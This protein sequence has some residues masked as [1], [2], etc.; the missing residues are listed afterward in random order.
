MKTKHL[1]RL[2]TIL[3]AGLFAMPTNAQTAL[4]PGGNA[5]TLFN[6]SS[7]TFAGDDGT[8]YVNPSFFTK[9]SDGSYKFNAITGSYLLQANSTLKYLQVRACDN[10]GTLSTL[11]A[12]GT[13]AVYII[14]EGIGFPTVT[15]NQVGWNTDKAISMAQTSAKKY[16]VTGVVGQEIGTAINFKFY[17]QAGWGTEFHGS[18]G[19]DYVATS[20]SN[21]LDVGQGKDVN[22]HDDGNLFLKSGAE[23]AMGDT[24]VLTLDLTEGVKSGVLSTTLKK[25]AA[26][27][28]PTFNGNAFTNT[29]DGYIY[30][31]VITQGGT[32]TFAGASQFGDAD[33]HMDADFFQSKGDGTFTFIP[34]T[35]RYEIMAD[36]TLKY[37][38]VF[39]INDDNSVATYNKTTGL[40]GV[41]AIGDTGFGKPSFSKN[42]HNWYT[43]I[44]NDV[45]LA[46]ISNAKYQLTLNSG[47]ELKISDNY[48][49]FKFFGQ[50]DW[51]TEFK[52]DPAI[53]MT[54]NDYFVLKDG[55][56]N[57]KEGAT[58]PAGKYVFTLDCAD[59]ANAVLTVNITTGISS[60]TATDKTSGEEGY[61]TLSGMK[62]TKPVQKG[63]Y[64][65]QGKKI[66]VR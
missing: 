63:I 45:P 64:I 65:H 42:G 13:G 32:C 5:Q 25:A 40:G 41:W 51:G 30:Q 62:V 36:F 17:G 52:T 57:V 15:D 34:V 27:F 46:Q 7:Y 20:S 48:V 39:A 50:P 49:S 54:D 4:T 21:L 47:T 33:W 35:G 8:W 19:S 6:G 16:E 59:P 56:V 10:T 53:T 9:K 66:I 11:Q 2:G 61:Y 26:V 28:A 60:V 44:G 37:F 23:V 58:V 43:G 18:T 14:G 22:G 38:K 24:I 1:L 29:S 12:D 3:M 31:G 55:N